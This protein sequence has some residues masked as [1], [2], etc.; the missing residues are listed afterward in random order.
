MGQFKE[1]ELVL[2]WRLIDDNIYIYGT[3]TT[4][5][6]ERVMEM[7]LLSF[8]NIH[9]TTKR[10]SIKF[11]TVKPVCMLPSFWFHSQRGKLR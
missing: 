1:V 5:E 4:N 9:E 7:S 8:H 10:V 3:F 11:I 6:H 2:R